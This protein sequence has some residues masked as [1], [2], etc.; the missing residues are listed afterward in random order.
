MPPEAGKAGR[1]SLVGA[2]PGDPELLTLRAARLIGEADVILHD[3][4]VGPG[5]LSLAS[6]TARIV[7]VGKRC[8]CH[9]MSQAEINRLIVGFAL[10]GAHVVRLKGGDPFVF[11]RGGEELEAVRSAGLPYRIVPGV[12]AGCAAA[13]QLGIPLTQRGVGRSLHFVSGH[14]ADAQDIDYDWNSLARRDSTLVVYMGAR[15]L[16]VMTERM[17]KAGVSPELPAV[18]I[19]NATLPGERIVAGNVRTIAA[20]VDAA[21]LAGPTLVIFG[22]VARYCVSGYQGCVALGLNFAA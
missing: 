12:T 8:G 21:A 22:E 7:D 19:E 4:L 10:S 3:R 18:T 15:R 13:A 14:G 17:V 5:V 20:L 2:G 16:A 11:G 9:S 6:S 1:V